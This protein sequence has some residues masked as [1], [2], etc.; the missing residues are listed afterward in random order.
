MFLIKDPDKDPRA[1]EKV[2]TIGIMDAVHRI[3]MAETIE[4][5][6][7][8]CQAAIEDLQDGQLDTHQATETYAW[9]QIRDCL[10]RAQ[11]TA[12]A[13]KK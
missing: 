8:H 1:S 2:A 11:H 10:K 13:F 3:G 7:G 6:I 5:L 4:H 9:N 12:K